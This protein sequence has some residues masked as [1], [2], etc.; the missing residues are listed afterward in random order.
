MF[1]I[2]TDR[3]TPREPENASGYED[4]LDA[5]L[6]ARQT[7][8]HVADRLG[9]DVAIEDD[10]AAVVAKWTGIPVEKMLE[11]EMERLVKMEDRLAARVIGQAPAIAATAARK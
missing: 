10:I 2:L 7:A 8:Q 9:L 11:G 5:M 6:R 1:F 3:G 4:I